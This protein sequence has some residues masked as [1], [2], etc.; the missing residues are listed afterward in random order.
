M[1]DLHGEQV[2]IVELLHQVDLAEAT[3][4]DKRVDLEVVGAH[5]VLTEGVSVLAARLGSGV[6]DTDRVLVL[7]VDGLVEEGL[8]PGIFHRSAPLL[9][10][11]A[12]VGA[13]AAE[14]QLDQTRTIVHGGEVQAR[15]AIGVLGVDVGAG[16]EQDLGDLVVA[17]LA[18]NHERSLE[19][20]VER[21]DLRLVVEEEA[22]DFGVPV[23]DADM[24][25]GVAIDVA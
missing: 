24:Q 16:I 6:I 8:I 22:Y 23:E 12:E 15:V 25:D 1:Q 17:L 13:L 18:R 7:L 11:Q 19:A 14:E 9:I 21:V 10:A 3:P 5:L 2:V 4:A 20:R